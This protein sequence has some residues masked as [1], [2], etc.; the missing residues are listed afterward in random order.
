MAGSGRRIQLNLLDGDVSGKG[1]ALGSWVDGSIV[2]GH[3]QQSAGLFRIDPNMTWGNQLIAND[4]EGGYYRFDYQSRQW[5]TDV[6]LDE[7]RSVSAISA[8]TPRFSQAMPA[9]KS[10]AIGV[11]AASVT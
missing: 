11:W 7:V 10:C 8:T 3:I 2:E 1:N 6:G 4:A 5:M 9:I